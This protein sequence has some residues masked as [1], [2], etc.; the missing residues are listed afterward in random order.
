MSSRA[1]LAPFRS[2]PFRLLF[3]GRL[4]DNL[5]NAVA[6]IALAFAVLDLGGSPTVLG[7]VLAARTLPMVLLVLFG[8][9][10]ADRLP[11]H[12]V[13]VAANVVSA[14]TQALVAV[15]LLTGTADLWHL[16]A[17]EAVNG[18]SSAF[19]MPASSGLTPE[20]V[21][22]DQLQPA[23]ALLRL[24]HNFSFVTGSAAGGA[25]VAISGSGWAFAAD[26]V[27]FAI[28]AALLGRIR[29][30]HSAR[31]ES[32]TVLA[33]LREGWSE[34]RSRTW[35]WVIVVQFAFVNAATSGATN[36][37]GPVVADDTI[38]RAAW[39]LVL[40]SMTAGMFAGGLLALRGRWERPLMVG[41]AAILLDVPVLLVLG[42]APQTVPLM[43][44]AFVAGLGFETF[45]VAW[46]VA[47]QSNI[48]AD[49]LS[50]VYAYDWFGSLV[51]IPVGLALAGP[52]S[53][54]VGVRP[55][56]VGAAVVVAVATL[57]ALAVPSVRNLRQADAAA[58]VSLPSPQPAA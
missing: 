47:M 21:P 25:L 39:G 11:R 45:G 36:A 20:T 50:R 40:A 29:L 34:F 48:P 57:T 8:G 35:L 58:D 53:A 18:V 31:L 14:G 56:I 6:P 52:V 38:G 44:A 9:V 55:T 4:T 51:F 13:L 46:D 3:G 1:A 37:L 49:R 15:L 54:L 30:P 41:T 12:L 27:L 17:I 28:G 42:I 10:I 43:V 32:N 5:A 24:G 16:A 26:A 23:N 22:P 19:M 7:L 33:D 2:R